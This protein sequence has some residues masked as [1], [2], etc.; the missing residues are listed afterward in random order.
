MGIFK[1]ETIYICT[2]GKKPFVKM[3]NKIKVI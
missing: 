3:T 2:Q 1:E